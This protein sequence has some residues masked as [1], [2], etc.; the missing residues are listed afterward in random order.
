[1]KTA[2]LAIVFT[3][4]KGFTERT[5]RQT[6]EENQ[7]LLQVHHALLAP[8]FKAFGGRIIK[9][10]GDA[11]LVTFESPTQA[12]LSGIAIQDRLWHHNRSV[13]EADQLHVRVAINV[14]EVRL[15]SNDI[16]GEPVNIAARVEGIAEAGEV[17]FTEAVY[18]AMNKA[19]VPSKEVGA[20]ELKGIPGKIRVFHV[21]RAPYRVEAPSA[22]A[23]AE[24]PDTASMPPFG[25]LA[26][27]RVSES[28]LGPPVDLAMLGQRAATGAAVLGQRAVAGASV[29][30]QRAAAGASVLGQHAATGASVL[31]QHARTAGGSLFSRLKGGLPKGLGE[32][33]RTLV[34]GRKALVG[35]GLLAVVAG[36]AVV[37]FGGGAA[38]RAI[39]AVEDAPSDERNALVK[40]ARRLI[41][42]EKDTGRRYY[43]EGRLEEAM[44]N[45]SG[46]LGEYSRAAKAGNGAAKDRIIDLLEHSQCGVRSSAAYAVAGLKLE[47]AVGELEDLADDGGP[48]DG[49][50]GILGMGKCDS[51]KAAQSAL[52]SF[53]KD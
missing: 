50:G 22:A 27:S 41:Q 1:M 23:I 53:K 45:V 4:I 18:L 8:L 15:E 11:F 20:F 51:K 33:A 24:P 49:S 6:L 29:L 48:D 3:D 31:G 52:K 34:A 2:N 39:D 46:S 26:L 32:R 44:G 47:S 19:E 40:D 10:I 13:E 30:G 38:M 42:A 12:V 35:L 28:Q 25:N 7:R 36:G 9:S 21:P 37:A 17:Y 14:G 5:S 16:F 43:L